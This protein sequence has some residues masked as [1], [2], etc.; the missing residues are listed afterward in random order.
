MLLR[1]FKTGA[2]RIDSDVC[3]SQRA[4]GL[5]PFEPFI[6]IEI[7]DADPRI[8]PEFAGISSR[9]SE[10]FMKQV[11]QWFGLFVR[12]PACGHP[13]VCHPCRSF[14]GGLSRASKPDWD[15]SLNR[16][17][18]EARIIDRESCAAMRHERLGP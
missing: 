1:R 3:C 2:H 16:H 9:L 10:V 5:D 17:R 18:I 11:E 14:D 4:P 13:T 8:D 7:L 15:W 12:W 6:L